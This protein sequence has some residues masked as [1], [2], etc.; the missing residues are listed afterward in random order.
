MPTTDEIEAFVGEAALLGQSL[1]VLRD[2][3]C[4]R[5]ASVA[6]GGDD[7]WRRLDARGVTLEPHGFSSL[8]CI[9]CGRPIKLLGQSIVNDVYAYAHQSPSVAIAYAVHGDWPDV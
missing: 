2:E 6:W 4:K 7:A 5:I 3:Q 8:R 9:T 1:W